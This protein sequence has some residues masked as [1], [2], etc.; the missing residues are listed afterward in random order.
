M[1][2]QARRLHLLR[3][4]DVSGVSGTGIVAFGVQFPDG[5]IVLNW[6]TKVSSITIYK[7]LS[8]LQQIVGHG[9]RTKVIYDDQE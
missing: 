5:T 7:S 6:D 8:D 1:D 3:T 4:E 9:G 2:R